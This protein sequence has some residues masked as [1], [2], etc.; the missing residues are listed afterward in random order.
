MF[1]VSFK[2]RFIY[3]VISNITRSG[4]SFLTGIVVARGLGPNDYGSYMF[5]LGSFTAVRQL[6]DL[7]T[8]TAFYTF[9]SRQPKEK[10]FYLSYAA[11]Q[12]A[13]FIVTVLVIGLLLPQQWIDV[14]WLGHSR[15]IVLTAFVAIF[16]QQ[17][18]W[19]TVSQLAESQ[20]L[21]HWIQRL[22]ISIAVVHA[23]LMIIAW[24]LHALSVPLIFGLIFCE[25]LVAMAVSYKALPQHL[26]TAGSGLDMRR[27]IRDY[28][29]YCTPL[30]IYSGMGFAHTF[31]ENW[32]LQ[33]FG[34]PTQ[35]A[36]YAVT[37]QFAA[38]SLLAT[39]AIQQI[40]WKEMAE[41]H[42]R[43]DHPRLE[44]LYELVPRF[45]ILIAATL[46][47]FLFP[48]SNEIMALVYGPAYAGAGLVLAIM[49]LTPIH[50]SLGIIIGTA[51]LA[52]GNV[53]PLTTM[54]L[55]YMAIS[56]PMIYFLLAP[57]DLIVP[58]LSLGAL[59]MAGK[60]F[61]VQIIQHNIAAWWFAR[62]NGFKF[63]YGYQISGMAVTLLVG[64]IVY[65]AAGMV[66]GFAPLHIIAKA[67]ISGVL[68][69]AT[70]VFL[71]W[72]APAIF[73]F[74]HE[75]LHRHLWTMVKLPR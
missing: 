59:G 54:G 52:T 39:T 42:Q 64:V 31:A 10:L 58:G 18:A 55:G 27:M 4:L 13:Q 21:T 8:S 7:G 70:I 41:A 71:L 57:N 72:K 1:K 14:I 44:I 37:L 43:A 73:G 17:Q 62:I 24:R 11:W 2:S 67:A 68:Y 28:I 15:E 56:I 63:A 61:V 74:T 30:L 47:G 40:F 36:F 33:R 9:I 75:D 3:T 66:A 53:K 50:N 19:L 38:I 46:C 51:Y 60:L 6:L 34:G 5:L 26:A 65:Q 23:G 32:M 49:L 16:L 35:Q 29:G 25:Y 45:T 22:N 20:R 48:W 69:M 12:A